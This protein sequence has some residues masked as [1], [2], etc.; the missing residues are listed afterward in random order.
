VKG[1]V[2]TGAAGGIGRAIADQAAR[3]GYRV[4]L[5]DL[6]ADALRGLA[7]TLPQAVALV[8]NTCDEAQVEA[9]LDAFGTPDV[10]VG[11]AGIVR[12]GPLEEIALADFHAVVEVNLV[13]TFVGARAAARRMIARGRGGAIVNITSMNGVVPGQRA[14]A[15]GATKAGVALLTQQM[16]VE[17][18]RFGIRANCVAPGLV[19]AGMSAP[20]LADPETRRAR[21]GKVP[22]G[23]LASAEDIARAVLFLAGDDAAYVTGQNLLVDGGVTHSILSHLPRPASV[24]RP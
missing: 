2:V 21:E 13:G 10:W 23:R 20:I 22:L 1:L 3:A 5:L 15:Y 12:F 24:D 8:A 18:G 16:A 14:G 19:A 9:A 11:N 7:A 17:W 6:S 4:G